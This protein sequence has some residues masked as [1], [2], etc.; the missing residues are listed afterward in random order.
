MQLSQLVR[1]R[2]QTLAWTTWTFTSF[3]GPSLSGK[4][5]PL[6]SMLGTITCSI[7]HDI[8]EKVLDLQWRGGTVSAVLLD[9]SLGLDVTY[10]M[11]AKLAPRLAQW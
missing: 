2:S 7:P 3:T 5:W 4:G 8:V 6:V 11:A 10:P 9:R 1:I